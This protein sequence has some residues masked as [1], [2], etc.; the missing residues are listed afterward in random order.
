MMKKVL[1]I[2]VALMIVLAVIIFRTKKRCWSIK[3]SKNYA[4]DFQVF[5][6]VQEY[7]DGLTIMPLEI[8]WL[9]YEDDHN[10]QVRIGCFLF[11]YCIYEIN[12]YNINHIEEGEADETNLK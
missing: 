12:V 6:K 9:R 11:N 8:V 4:L 3:V 10:P 1:V 7:K 5:Q 2:V